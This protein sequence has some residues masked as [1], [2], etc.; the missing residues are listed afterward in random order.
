M[1]KDHWTDYEVSDPDKVLNGELD[2]FVEAYLRSTV[3]ARV[4]IRVSST[5]IDRIHTIGYSAES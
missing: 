2:G 4:R 5:T 1:V 3:D